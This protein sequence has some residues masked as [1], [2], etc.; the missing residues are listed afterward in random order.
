MFNSKHFSF[1]SLLISLSWRAASVG[2]ESYDERRLGV[3]DNRKLMP[4]VSVNHCSQFFLF[5]VHF[6]T[7]G[8]VTGKIVIPK[9]IQWYRGRGGGMG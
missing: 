4:G 7:P 9:K 5:F 2:G 8:M 1:F 3:G 6:L